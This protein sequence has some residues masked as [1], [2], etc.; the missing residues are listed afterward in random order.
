MINR[1]ATIRWKGYDPDDLS[2]K[3]NKKICCI[4]DGCGKVRWVPKYAYNDLCLQ[5]A[6]KTEEFRSKRRNAAKRDNL[7]DET[8]KKMSESSK[9]DNLSDETIK[10]MSEGV[11]RANMSVETI[12]KRSEASKRENLS[13]KTREK[14]SESSKREN[15]PDEERQLRSNSASGEN[16]P[17]WKGGISFEPYCP[18]FTE[19]LKQR[20][21]EQYN[22]CDYLSGLS[23]Y[24]C[25]IMKNGKVWKLDIHHIDYNKM[26][27]CDGIR[28]LLI[29]VSKR[30]N[31]MFNRNRLFWEKLICYA[32]EYDKTYYCE[33]QINCRRLHQ[34]DQKVYKV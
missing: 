16:N 30:N 5:C 31:A 8:L 25:N 21:R 24:I 12:K 22:N 18:K 29:P 11:K 19:K 3:S 15:M 4:C 1:K 23:D 6:C 9:R 34:R 27:G 13:D 14:M 7:S 2:F 20:V 28:W 33:E 10:K 32:L 26:Q 17:N